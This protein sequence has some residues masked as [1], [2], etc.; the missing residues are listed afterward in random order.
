MA[1]KKRPETFKRSQDLQ[2]A[3]DSTAFTAL[4]FLLNVY[5]NN[6]DS[7]GLPFHLADG[8]VGKKRFGC[9]D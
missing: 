9:F 4:F 1:K 3:V 2:T 8:T 6:Q 5:G 7:M